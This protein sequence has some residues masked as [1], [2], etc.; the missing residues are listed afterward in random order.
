MYI[1]SMLFVN[2]KI[3][4]KNNSHLFLL[5]RLILK[6]HVSRQIWK[7]S[8]ARKFSSVS[9]T[10]KFELVRRNFFPI[11]FLIHIALW[12]TFVERSWNGQEKNRN[13][14]FKFSFVSHINHLK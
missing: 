12:E 10:R 4:A 1:I 14:K 11:E 3:S 8:A 6:L 9:F 2:L 13:L 7:V 5:F